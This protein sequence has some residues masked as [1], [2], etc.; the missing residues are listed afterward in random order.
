MKRTVADKNY[1]ESDELRSYLSQSKTNFVIITDYAQVEMLKD[2]A[3]VNI[4]KSTEIVAEFPRQVRV[5]KPIER[6]SRL[7]CEAPTRSATVN[8]GR[9]WGMRGK[10]IGF[11]DGRVVPAVSR[12]C[13]PVVARPKEGSASIIPRL[14]GRQQTCRRTKTPALPL[15]QQRNSCPYQPASREMSLMLAIPVSQASQNWI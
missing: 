14:I 5:L 10:G 3:L 9:S 7:P 8:G 13:E 6:P 1:L 2:N 15:E 11:A 12:P 4:L